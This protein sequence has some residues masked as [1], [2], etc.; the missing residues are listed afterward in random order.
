MEKGVNHAYI[1]IKYKR[2]G[3]QIEKETDTQRPAEREKE[4]MSAKRRK[5]KQSKD[6]RLIYDIVS[7]EYLF[8][9][10]GFAFSISAKEI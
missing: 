8:L 5:K 4:R 3:F 10:F 6:S 7:C 9:V 2:F 1:K